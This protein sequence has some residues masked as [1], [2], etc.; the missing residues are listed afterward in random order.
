MDFSPPRKI[1][2]HNLRSLKREC[3]KQ[4]W[5]LQLTGSVMLVTCGMGRPMFVR[6]LAL[7]ILGAVLGRLPLLVLCEVPVE[8]IWWYVKPWHSSSLGAVRCRFLPRKVGAVTGLRGILAKKEFGVKLAGVL[9]AVFLS[10]SCVCSGLLFSPSQLLSVCLS[11]FMVLAE[12]QNQ[13]R[14]LTK[15]VILSKKLA[16]HKM[17]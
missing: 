13:F 11:S 5:Y 10:S 7:R 12:D 8:G 9:S 3:Q 2:N 1:P 14:L 6:L 17:L 15:L 4:K 16:Y